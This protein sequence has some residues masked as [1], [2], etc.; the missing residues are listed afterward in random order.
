MNFTK[1]TS[2]AINILSDVK[3]LNEGG[4]ADHCDL[5]VSVC[6]FITS[7]MT[8]PSCMLG[9]VYYKDL[10]SLMVHIKFESEVNLPE[11]IQYG[12]HHERVYKISHGVV[13]SALLVFFL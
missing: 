8:I 5:E 11:G 6:R 1:V 2:L 7:Q 9:Q 4:G 13:V 12:Y 3:F 10:I